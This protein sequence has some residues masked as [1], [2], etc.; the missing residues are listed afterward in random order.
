MLSPMDVAIESVD[1]PGVVALL[2]AGDAFYVDLYPPEEVFLLNLDELREPTV[3]IAIGRVDGEAVGMG[4]LVE[5]VGYGEIKR[6][7]VADA[8]RGSGLARLILRALEANAIERGIHLL[9][10]ETGPAQLA[11]IAFYQREGF[12]PIPLFGE[13]IGSGS[14]VCFQKDLTT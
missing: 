7:Y 14:S 2:E 11:A 1:A 9:K 12:T 3:S 5:R 8:A 6:M 4:A 13:Y 10:L